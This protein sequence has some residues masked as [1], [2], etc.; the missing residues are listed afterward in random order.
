MSQSEF[1]TANNP[2]EADTAKIIY[3]LYLVGWVIPVIPPIVG[4]VMAYMNREG[5]PVW[6]QS[7]YQL[8][9]RT[10]WMGMLYAVIGS[11]V[12]TFIIN[13]IGWLIFVL[14][15]IWWIVRC[16]KGLKALFDGAPYPNPTTWVW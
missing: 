6:V 11:V 4:L 10:F 3:I 5:A 15:L 8:Q 13:F 2:A 7:H 12:A 14:M 1:I 9:I 16:V